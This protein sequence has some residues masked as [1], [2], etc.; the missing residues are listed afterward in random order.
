ML[1]GINSEIA[2]KKLDTEPINN[3]K[4]LETKI[5]PYGNKATDFCD[6]EIPVIGSNYTCL[7]VIL[8]D[9]IHK[10]EKNCYPQLFLKEC[11]YI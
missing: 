8:I 10:K 7:G 5:K 1:F 4:F 11:K 9:F 3:K 6:K 2:W